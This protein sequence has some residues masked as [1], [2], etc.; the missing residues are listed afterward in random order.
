VSGDQVRDGQNDSL[1]QTSARRQSDIDSARS[2]LSPIIKEML[3]FL[4][5]REGLY[6]NTDLPAYNAAKRAL[7][8]DL[9]EEQLRKHRADWEKAPQKDKAKTQYGKYLS[10]NMFSD[11]QART[12]FESAD[13]IRNNLNK[14]NEYRRVLLD[15][16]YTRQNL[17]WYFGKDELFLTR[18]GN[19]KNPLSKTSIPLGSQFY[20]QGG[21]VMPQTFLAGGFARGTDTIPAMLTPGEF[22]VSQPAVK[23]FGVD[24]LKSI[25]SGTY[26]GDSVYNYSVN[27]NVA[28]SGANAND[29]ARTVMAQIKQIDSQRIRSNVL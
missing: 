15:A 29:I 25:N 11:D 21:M 22:I 13:T 3:S 2:N 18:N 8:V 26:G 20:A 7:G 12:W 28:N 23:S 27:V 14:A 4:K 24:N 5:R 6:K 1:I 17:A 9:T 16:G 19:E 10:S